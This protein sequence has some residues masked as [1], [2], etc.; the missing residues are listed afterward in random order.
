[1]PH[2]IT[3]YTNH[4]NLTF[5]RSAHRIAR[6]VARYLG[7]LANYHFTLVHK[8]GT[9]NHTDA[10]SRWPDHD[11]ETLDNE[12]IVVLGPELFANAI[13]LLNLEQKVFTVQEEYKEW[14]TELQQSSPLDKIEG[15]WFYCGCPVVP[16]NEEL[17]RE[18]LKQYHGHPLAGHPGIMN[19]IATLARDF[20]WPMLKHFATG[21]V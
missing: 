7:K 13:E 14:I 12:D 21:Y 16:R 19:M 18:I 2:I 8:P 4:K 3:I 15:R 5:Y 6:R 10:F 1:M 17:Q 20:W 11:T 9:L